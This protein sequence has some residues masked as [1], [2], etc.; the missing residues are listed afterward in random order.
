MFTVSLTVRRR[1]VSLVLAMAMLF[2]TSPLALA[3]EVTSGPLASLAGAESTL[4]G[5]EEVGALLTRVERLEQD[6]F[7]A[8]QTGALV[9]RLERIGSTLVAPV[10][11]AS[12]LSSLATLEWYVARKVSADPVMKRVTDLEALVLGQIQPGSLSARMQNLS[13][14]TWPE[15]SFTT[16]AVKLPKGTLVKIKLL[17]ELNSQS[18][19]V[20]DPV[21]FRVAEDVLIDGKLVIPAGVAGAGKVAE[22]NTAGN[23][24]RDGRVVVNFGSILA[25]DGR[26]VAVEVNEHATEMNKSLQVAAG[27]S[28][29]GVVLLG[30]VGLVGGFFVKGKNVII[31]VG[32]EF[33]IE[34][35]APLDVTGVAIK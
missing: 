7:G 26:P 18:S 17:T 19:K 8:P 21:S 4:Y 10:G 32:T 33:F 14:L 13:K 12:I 15:G 20:A 27:A 22:V 1:V 35:S 5:K 23:M 3:W 34:V 29:A 2:G 24:G 28:M 11:Q 30:P 31:P 25:L 9:S 16:A 6:L